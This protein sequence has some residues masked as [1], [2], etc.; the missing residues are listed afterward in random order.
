MGKSP[1]ELFQ[2]R[3]KRLEDAIALRIP[4]R[5]PVAPVD[6][7]FFVEYAGT[8]WEEV[9]YDCEKATAASKKTITELQFDAYWPPAIFMSGGIQDLLNFKQVKWPG[10]ADP[11]NR[12]ADGTYQYVEPG[13]LYPEMKAEEYDWFLDDPSDYILRGHLPK[14]FKALEPL[15]TLPHLSMLVGYYV[16]IPQALPLLSSPEMIAGLQA[17]AEAAKIAALDAQAAGRFVNEMAQLGYPIMAAAFSIAPFDYF[18][19]FLRGGRGALTDMYRHPDKLKAAIA[20]VTP[21]IIDWTL[22]MA[23]P[24]KNFCNRIFIPIHKSAGVFMSEEQHKEFFWPS[25]REVIVALVDAGLTPYLYTEGEFS[26]RLETIKDVPKG[27]VLY[28]IEKDLFKAKEILGD[29]V[30]LSGG[31]PPSVMNLGTPEEVKAWSKKII[32]IVGKDGGFIMDVE[33][34]MITAKP[35]NVRALVEFTKEYGVY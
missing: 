15:K 13:T 21:W 34:T 20:R 22:S 24:M 23:L 30:C 28:H 10:A 2:E 35:E 31:P 32:D 4:D 17:L 3:N 7:G 6:A 11:S 18:A 29:T 26:A 8:T 16:G 33:H 19:D 25:M 12:V 1:Q 14:I 5:V 27:K 9:M